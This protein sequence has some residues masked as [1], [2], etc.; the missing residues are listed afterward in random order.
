M[1][2]E[3]IHYETDNP[4]R[5]AISSKMGTKIMT[6]PISIITPSLNQA[7]YIEN[8]IHSI[9]RQNYSAVEHIV[10]DG[11]S[12]DGSL[13]ILTRYPQIR[14]VSEP[15]R[16]MYDALNKGL[17]LAR[18]EIVGFLNADDLYADHVFQTVVEYFH[19]KTLD[20]LSGKAQI[21]EEKDCS[22]KVVVELSPSPPDKLV[23]TALT[24]STIFNAWF[25]R[26]SIIQR[27]GGFDA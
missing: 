9:L 10:V 25:Y 15:D 21:F 27:A 2:G 6:L 17:R 16:G 8:A 4:M 19:D 13:D 20:V 11:G 7:K 5:A 3:A 18:G 14:V 24:G 26:K 1:L 22:L 12:T 23:E